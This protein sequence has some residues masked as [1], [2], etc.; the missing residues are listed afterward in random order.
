MTARPR[1]NGRAGSALTAR[2]VREGG[3][4][5]YWC[6]CP[7]TTRDHYPVPHSAG[8]PDTLGNLVAACLPCNAARHDTP[9]PPRPCPTCGVV[10][11]PRPVPGLREGWA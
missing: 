5:C 3:G 6:A 7:A 10:K 11:H 8:G 9:H 4:V 2:V 1:R